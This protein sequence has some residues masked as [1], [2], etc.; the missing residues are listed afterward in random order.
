MDGYLWPKFK[1]QRKQLHTLELDDCDFI[2]EDEVTSRRMVGRGHVCPRCSGV[3]RLQTK[4]PYCADCNW[5]SL[6]DQSYCHTD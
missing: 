5:D 2:P 6:E 4:H 1:K 3:T